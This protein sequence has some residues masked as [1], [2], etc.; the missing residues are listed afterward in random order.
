[1][2]AA[3]HGN[4]TG[5]ARR[6]IRIGG[7]EQRFAC[8]AATRGGDLVTIRTG[9]TAAA[10]S[11]WTLPVAPVALS[12]V[13]S[14]IVTGTDRTVV[15][16]DFRRGTITRIRTVGTR[17][18]VGVAIGVEYVVGQ[19]CLTIGGGIIAEPALAIVVHDLVGGRAA[20]VAARA[21]VEAHTRR[22]CTSDGI[23]LSSAI[24]AAPLLA[25][26]TRIVEICI[27]GRALPHRRAQLIRAVHDSASAGYS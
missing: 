8:T 21:R 2:S 12:A 13:E 25:A 19:R 26:G 9:T 23:A 7:I 10:R 5:Q 6:A 22:A 4:E 11:R 27:A 1:M 24:R 20:D 17:T 14:G 16:R 18:V 15:G 3:V